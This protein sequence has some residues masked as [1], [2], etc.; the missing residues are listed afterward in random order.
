MAG[1]HTTFDWTIAAVNVPL[2]VLT[3]G[4]VQFSTEDERALATTPMPD[5]WVL[6][7]AGLTSASNKNLRKL[8]KAFEAKGFVS[9]NDADRFCTV[10][11]ERERQ[12]AEKT[13]R[14]RAV[15]G[16]AGYLA[17][18][19]RLSADGIEPT[20]DEALSSLKGYASDLAK[21]GAGLAAISAETA[22]WAGKGLGV[23]AGAL[24]SVRGGPQ[25]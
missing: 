16:S 3:Y 25:G 12:A 21:A 23:V 18:S 4:I 2:F 6:S 8:Q 24:R 20:I 11:F 22:V 5:S 17:L 7:A 10:E 9:I 15:G 14:E 19:T 13:A 1:Q